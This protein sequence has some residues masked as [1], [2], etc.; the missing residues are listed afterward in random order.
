MFS[1]LKRSLLQCF[2]PIHC[3]LC[4]ELTN[5]SDD[6]CKDCLL[7]LPWMKNACLRCG[8]ALFKNAYSI[9]DR[10]ISNPP[11]FDISVIPFNYQ[12]PISDMISLLKFNQ[13][14]IY[15][16]ILAKLMIKRLEQIHQQFLL[17]ELI[18]PIPLHVKRLR[19]RGFN[20]ALEI[21]KPIGKYF[22]IPVDFTTCHRI[23]ET[24]PQS[25]LPAK[26][27]RNNIKNVFVVKKNLL[28][29]HVAVID[30]V[31][32]TGNTIDEF[33]KVLKN[34]GIEK[35]QIWSCAHSSIKH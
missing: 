30:D 24:E 14:I 22:N 19:E 20:Q 11:K 35:I 31:V 7:L 8:N 33:S 1:N 28:A 13:K 5:H 12:K 10:C 18:I 3:V 23:K 34:E 17:P 9:C 16:R 27:R 26:K 32:T 4:Q 21:A 25:L 6:F 15:S 2:Y 29:K